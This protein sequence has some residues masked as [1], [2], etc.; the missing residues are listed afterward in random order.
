M[1]STSNAQR[2]AGVGLASLCAFRM[3]LAIVEDGAN[4]ARTGHEMVGRPRA[5][6]G[7]LHALELPQGARIPA[8][9]FFYSSGFDQ[10]RDVQHHSGVNP[11]AGDF[12]LQW[13]QQLI[14][15]NR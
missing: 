15:L 6:E 4:F 5:S 7:N 14:Y 2:E 1:N 12:F 8:L 3:R 9:V 13:A 11:F 10:V